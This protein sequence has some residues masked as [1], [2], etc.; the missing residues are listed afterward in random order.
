MGI[1]IECTVG[2]HEG[3]WVEFKSEGWKRKHRRTFFESGVLGD[4]VVWA[5]VQE[6]LDTWNLIGEDNKPIPQPH[7]TEPTGEV[8]DI[9]LEDLDEMSLL[10]WP[11]MVNSFQQALLEVMGI[12]RP[13]SADSG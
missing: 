6:R 3:E 7:K 12:G 4:A 5:V 2:G 8:T 9:I 1:R 13:F 11:W 10:V